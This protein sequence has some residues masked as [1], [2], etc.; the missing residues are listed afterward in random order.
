M[1]AAELIKELKKYPLELEI[2]IEVM[3]R[4]VLATDVDMASGGASTWLIITDYPV[5][6]D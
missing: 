6:H 5:S 4:E 2:R 1:T 3:G